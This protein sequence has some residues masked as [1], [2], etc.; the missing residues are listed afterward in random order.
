MERENLG[1]RRPLAIAHQDRVLS[2]V[3]IQGALLRNDPVN[4]KVTALR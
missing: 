2:G 4:W 1:S 3:G